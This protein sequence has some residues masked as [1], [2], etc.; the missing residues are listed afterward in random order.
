METSDGAV[1]CEQ[2]WLQ[3]MPTPR[4]VFTP[5]SYLEVIPLPFWEMIF[6]SDGY[7]GGQSSCLQELRQSRH[8]PLSNDASS[9]LVLLP[10][11]VRHE[12]WIF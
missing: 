4:Q 10:T 12:A 9:S 1:G 3:Q 8:I 5:V 7:E 6:E 2:A 11:P